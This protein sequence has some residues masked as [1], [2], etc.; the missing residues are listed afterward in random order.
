MSKPA[1][2][3]HDMDFRCTRVKES[4][5]LSLVSTKELILVRKARLRGSII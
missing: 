5:K 2:I 3:A 4:F 1:E